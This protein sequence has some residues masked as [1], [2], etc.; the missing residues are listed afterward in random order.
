ML[1]RSPASGKKAKTTLIGLALAALALT[2]SACAHAT[3]TATTD[4]SAGATGTPA[5]ALRLG[6]FANVTHTTPIV[7]VANGF[8]TAK[9][10]STK[11][12]T[13]IFSSRPTEMTALL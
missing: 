13:Q 4:P 2:T 8:Y 12:S 1:L 6:Y 7:G 9:L 5:A 3:T 11:L 10:G